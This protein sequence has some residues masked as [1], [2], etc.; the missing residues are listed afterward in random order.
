MSQATTPMGTNLTPRYRKYWMGANW[1]CNGSISFI[2]D[3]VQNMYNDMD[4]S[5]DC[6]G[7]PSSLYL[8]KTSASKELCSLVFTD[9]LLRYKS[10]T[11]PNSSKKL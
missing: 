8:K 4:Y 9:W 5:K 1:K 6:L 3:S 2:K 7:K 11:L 10:F